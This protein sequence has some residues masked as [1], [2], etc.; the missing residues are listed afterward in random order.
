VK[1]ETD[2]DIS[3]ERTKVISTI[4][5]PNLMIMLGY[6]LMPVFGYL[7]GTTLRAI[8]SD[9][10]CHVTLYVPDPDLY[11]YRV[12]ITGNELIVECG[13]GI[14]LKP[15]ADRI[16][17]VVHSSLHLLGLDHS[18]LASEITVTKSQYGKIA[19]IDETARKDFVH[20][21]ST[22]TGRAFSLGR[23]A[24]WRP[25]LLLDDVVNDVRV[26]E[27]MIDDK[28]FMGTHKVKK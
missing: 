22:E 24:T 15:T 5:M 2:F 19:P 8:L 21:A 20:W 23:Y 6:E 25:G 3:E 17:S 7:P 18:Q 14:G 12:S 26:I 4:P 27:R 16:D 13:H 11:Y 10:D 9:C 28:Y 1:F